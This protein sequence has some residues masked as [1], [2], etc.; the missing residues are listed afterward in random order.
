L[1]GK[2]WTLKVQGVCHTQLESFWKLRLEVMGV[3][4]ASLALILLGVIE[5]RLQFIILLVVGLVIL[6]YGLLMKKEPNK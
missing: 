2:R 3:I 6:A 4:I 1:L 5:V